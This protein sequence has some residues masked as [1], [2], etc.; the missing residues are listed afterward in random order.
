MSNEAVALC[1][2]YKQIEIKVMSIHSLKKSK[3]TG[4]S[5]SI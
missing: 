3:Q 4:L 1:C 5:I 2:G